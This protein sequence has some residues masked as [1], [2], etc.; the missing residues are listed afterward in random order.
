M[1]WLPYVTAQYIKTTGDEAILQ[2]RIPFLSGLPLQNDELDV[3]GYEPARKRRHAA[4]TQRPVLWFD[5]RVAWF[6]FD[7]VMTGMMA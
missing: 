2:E 7:G 1:L 3:M 6:T 5:G 4:G